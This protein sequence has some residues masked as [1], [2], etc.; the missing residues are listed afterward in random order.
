MSQENTNIHVIELRSDTFTKPSAKMREAM[1][2]AEV[3]DSGYDE[4]PTTN[5][6]QEVVAEMLGK[7]HALFFPSST[8]CNLAAVMAHCYERGSEAIIG[9]LSHY[10]MWEQGGISQVAGV[11]VKQIENLKDG[12]FDLEKLVSL[13]SEDDRGCPVT[14][15]ICLENTQNYCGGRIL[16]LSF[17]EKVANV[18]KENNIF[19][20]LDGARILN[21][22]VGS[23]TDVKEI[24][25]YFDSV[26]ICFSKGVGAPVGSALAGS[27]EFIR[28]AARAR[29]VLGGSLRQSGVLTACCLTGLEDYKEKIALDHKNAKTLAEGIVKRSHGLLHVDLECVETN[30]ILVRSTDKRLE[31]KNLIKRLAEVKDEEIEVL[32]GRNCVKFGI[33]DK[34]RMRV[35]THCDVSENDVQLA[36]NKIELVCL[37]FVKSDGASL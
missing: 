14:K 24:C 11:Y 7:E 4:D 18:C 3:G 33:I 13:I 6:L 34:H 1:K 37:N 31:S 28:R 5:K 26:N 25:K 9:D 10:N 2:N 22:A 12:T 32:K 16:P 19:L 20:H 36:L 17:V 27:K 29:Q 8:M 35:L 21:A 15:L 23:N 30:I